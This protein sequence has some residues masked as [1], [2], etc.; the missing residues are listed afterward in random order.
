MKPVNEE[1]LAERIAYILGQEL[2]KVQKT[3]LVSLMDQLVTVIEKL[4]EIPREHFETA[5]ANG[6]PRK[7]VFQRYWEL[8]W[9]IERATTEPIRTWK[10]IGEWKEWKDVA[11]KNGV[12]NPLFSYRISKGMTPEEAATSPVKKRSSN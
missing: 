9:E 3:P 12:T 7:N 8:G 6:I 1:V 4:E 2:F 10:N 5:K 11:A